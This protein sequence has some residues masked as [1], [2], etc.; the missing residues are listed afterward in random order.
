MGAKRLED[1]AIAERLAELPEWKR[2]GDTIVRKLSLSTF[3]EAQRFVN[4]LC[5]L[6]EGLNH[7]PDLHWVYVHVTVALSTHDA[8]GLTSLDFRLAGCVDEVAR[9]F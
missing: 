5:D 4:R 3:R 9:D 6:A 1:P 7:H 2:E 8:G